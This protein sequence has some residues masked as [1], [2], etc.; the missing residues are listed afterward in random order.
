[1]PDP[2]LV[3]TCPTCGRQLHRTVYS[4]TLGSLRSPGPAYRSIDLTWRHED[5]SLACAEPQEAS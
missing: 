3:A 4:Y 1:M 2:P 5:G